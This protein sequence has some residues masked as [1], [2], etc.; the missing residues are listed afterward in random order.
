MNEAL[1]LKAIQQAA[2][3]A[4]IRTFLSSHNITHLMVERDIF[5]F[6]AKNNLDPSK[7]QLLNLFVAVSLIEL[8]ESGSYSLYEITPKVPI[9]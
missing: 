7:I 4:E 5:K 6:W 8:L 1:F 3:P 2:K 9:G